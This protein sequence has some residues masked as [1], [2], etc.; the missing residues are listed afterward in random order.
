MGDKACAVADS[1]G[2]TEARE[3]LAAAYLKRK[4]QLNTRKESA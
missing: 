3:V 4:K 2:D 1:M